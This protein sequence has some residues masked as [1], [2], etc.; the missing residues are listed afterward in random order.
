MYQVYIK[1][2]TGLD[3]KRLIGEFRDF[4]KAQEKIEAELA[5]NPD[6]KYVIEETN[7]SVDVYGNLI[8]DVVDE[9]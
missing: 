7:G 5:K 9:N 3:K 1:T 8:V 6:F 4:E 2:D